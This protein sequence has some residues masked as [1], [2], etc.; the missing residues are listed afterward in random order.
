MK[1]LMLRAGAAIAVLCACTVSAL[2]DA[3][4]PTPA[5]EAAGAL[6]PVALILVAAVAVLVIVLRLLRR[7]RGKKKEEDDR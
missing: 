4:A 7:R 1:K 2:A 5:E 6:W 3:L